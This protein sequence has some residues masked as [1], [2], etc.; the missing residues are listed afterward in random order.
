MAMDDTDTQ[1]DPVGSADRLQDQASE[2]DA[3]GGVGRPPDDE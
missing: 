2:G 3:Q 1:G